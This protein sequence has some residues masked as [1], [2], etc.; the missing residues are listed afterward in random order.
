MGLN[1]RAC[2]HWVLALTDL[3]GPEASQCAPL[4][5]D[6]KWINVQSDQLERVAS[7]LGIATCQIE[8]LVRSGVT[9]RNH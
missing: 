8:G 3:L 9:T 5:A 2:K 1:W 6:R 4:L 7:G